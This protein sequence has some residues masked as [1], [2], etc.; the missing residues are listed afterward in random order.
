MAEKRKIL[1]Q[2]DCDALPSVF[3]RVV[4]VDAGAEFVFSYGGV[5]AEMVRDL[6][7]GGI[8]TRGPEDLHRTAFFVGGSDVPQGEEV[9]RVVQDTFLGPLRC[10]VMLDCAGANTTA[11]AAVLAAARHGELSGR[12]TLVLG[13]TGPVGQRVTRLLARQG[14]IVRAGSR[15]VQRAEAV[16]KRV[17]SAVDGARVE[18][19]RTERDVELDK[20]LDGVEIVI[21]AGPPGVCVLPP[22]AR[23]KVKTLRVLIDLNAVP[24]EG[25]AGVKGSDSVRERDGVI[26]YGAIGVGGFKMKLHKAAVARLFEASDHVLDADEI[27]D[28]GLALQDV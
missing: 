16:A 21:A 8:F 14:A 13:S 10:S 12:R 9:L 4:A 25:I 27:F 23:E 17:A 26:G 22:E 7:Y 5:T 24:P 3:D 28:L 20:A 19:F 1:V 2:L 15:S 11:A 18:P 6:V